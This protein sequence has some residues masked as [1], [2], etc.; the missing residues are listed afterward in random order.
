MEAGSWLL[1]WVGAYVAAFLLPLALQ[2]KQLA[3][4]PPIAG[5]VLLA[6]QMNQPSWL[7]L[8][9][10]SLVFLYLMK[11]AVLLVS[12]AKLPIGSYLLYFTVWPGMEP[13]RR[14]SL[15]V[16][17]SRS[18]GAG[19]G[20]AGGIF[21]RGLLWAY[22][23]GGL[24]LLTALQFDRLGTFI[25][26]WLGLAAILLLVHFGFSGMLSSMMQL[27]GY[28]VKPL[29]DRPFASRSLREFWTKRWNRP[30]V[31]MDR[32]LFMDPLRKRFGM[33]GAVFG[34]F[35]IS[36]LLHEM[37]ISYPAGAGWGMPLAYF[38]L[39]GVLT[40][41]EGKLKLPKVFERPWTWFW[42]LAPLPLLFH[43]AFRFTFIVPLFDWIH[44]MITAQSL[45]RWIDLL[46][47]ALGIGHFLVLI[48]SFQVPFRLHWREELPKLSSFN[49]KL[50]WTLGS[51]TTMTIAAFG[52]FT[53]VMHQELM[54]G[55]RAALAVA[56]YIV[57]FWCVRLGTDIFYYKHADW[58]EGPQF[59]VGHALLNSL[60]AFLVFGYGGVLAWH[61]MT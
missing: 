46:L 4:L 15:G 28:P 3:F 7:K 50:V 26:S 13:L 37:A 55:D 41:A 52:T 22:V 56:C 24:G 12:G 40:L 20:D 53:L 57:L 34:V 11:S 25:V 5:L 61:W 6:L 10:A 14:R 27:A 38:A 33:R 58:P 2:L 23:G 42:I 21:L 29:F 59:V 54:R 18:R 30:F 51:F 9:C 32:I 31:E 1:I 16:G 48:A 60:F 39:Q 17:E 19:G 45:E 47:W 49:R 35:L 36:G 8:L 44:R 43:D